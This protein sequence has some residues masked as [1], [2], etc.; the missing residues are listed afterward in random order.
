MIIERIYELAKTKP[1]RAAIV[2]NGVNIS[3]V[4]FARAIELV[5]EEL[6]ASGLPKGRTAGIVIA[7]NLLESWA[8]NIAVRS[9]GADTI[10]ATKLSQLI[11]LDPP[12]MGCV[13]STGRERGEGRLAGTLS[14]GCELRLLRPIPFDRIFEGSVPELTPTAARY[15]GHYLYSSGT[16]GSYKKIFFD[17]ALEAKR[18]Q[19][20][21]RAL[22][23]PADNVH[24][25]MRMGLWSGNGWKTPLAH[26]S[27]GATVIFEQ[28]EGSPFDYMPDLNFGSITLTFPDLK[29]LAVRGD[30]R[31]FV[32][33]EC[34]ILS[35][36]GLV[37][38]T[39]FE[40]LQKCVPR[41]FIRHYSCTEL[42]VQSLISRIEQPSDLD[43]Y[44]PTP[45]KN[46][47]IVNEAENPLPAGQEGQLRIE[48]SDLDATGY[49]GDPVATAAAFRDGYFYP[50][51]I[52]VARADGRI[53]ILGRVADVINLQGRKVAV[54]PIEQELQRQ[55]GVDE[56]CVFAHINDAGREELIVAME[57]ATRPPE[58]KLRD[59]VRRFNMFERINFA[60]RDKF[61]RT[62]TGTQKVKRAALKAMLTKRG[63]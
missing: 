52:G 21:F 45:G 5:R 31:L 39:V 54:G 47:Q 36:F 23:T 53:S 14:S 42:A 58:H 63:G 61:P 38:K 18:A 15:G 24:H 60:L 8:I 62:E 19:S 4:A 2:F 49:T 7:G 34:R 50:G 37:S 12:D 41:Q 3:Y 29:R 22:S 44:I 13:L 33:P 40:A 57:T 11:E 43:W 1:D 35:S 9:L 17:A 56:V 10:V 26:W 32:N 27:H 25:V 16:T 51:D 46:V 59:V 28:R 48:L 20:R 30:A 6:K 55:L